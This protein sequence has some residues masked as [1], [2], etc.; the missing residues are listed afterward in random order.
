MLKVTLFAVCFRLKSNNFVLLID[1]EIK[2]LSW[3]ETEDA[4]VDLRSD[5][6]VNSV[7]VD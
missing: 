1:N 2:T 3:S 4:I 5:L 6:L 7:I